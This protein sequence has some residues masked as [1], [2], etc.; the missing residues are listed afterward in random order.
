MKKNIKYIIAGVV[1]IIL[2]LV[3]AWK[4]SQGLNVTVNENSEPD[5]TEERENVTDEEDK[6]A[7]GRYAESNIEAD[8][9]G[10]EWNWSLL[11]SEKIYDDGFYLLR[12]DKIYSLNKVNLSE[13]K[14]SGKGYLYDRIREDNKNTN[15]DVILA[16]S[17]VP[18]P[19]IK[20]GDLV[21]AYSE[22]S[23]PDLVLQKVNFHGWT[24]GAYTT[25]EDNHTKPAIYYDEDNNRCEDGTDSVVSN[26]TVYDKDGNI[27]DDPYNLNVYEPYTA[28]WY[29]GTRSAGGIFDARCRSFTIDDAEYMIRGSLTGK[30]YAEYDLSE[31]PVGTYL[32]LNNSKGFGGGGLITIE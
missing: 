6:S 25:I 31:V 5:Y 18:T 2:I 27:V 19:T 1:I 16:L 17:Y 7:D 26:F 30:D 14:L 8:D 12:N 3:V 11:E 10:F 15:Q 24:I 23:V 4:N 32:V 9:D 20:S 22:T 28:E 21:V 29:M 13:N